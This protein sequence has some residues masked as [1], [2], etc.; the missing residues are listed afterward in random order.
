MHDG[1]RDHEPGAGLVHDRA[2]GK[3]LESRR[4]IADVLVR[5]LSSNHAL[6]KTFE[7]IATTGPPPDDF[8]A[9]F[10]PSRCRSPRRP[11]RRARHGK[12][13]ARRR[14]GPGTT[15]GLGCSVRQ[16]TCHGILTRL[17]GQ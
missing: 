11:G 16:S 4:Q 5:S 13:A 7:L 14:A 10:A 2:P 15:S 17:P 6:R 3:V 1:A 8:D 12:P 9:L